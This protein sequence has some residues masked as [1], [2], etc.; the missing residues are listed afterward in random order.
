MKRFCILLF[1]LLI[2]RASVAQNLS[3]YENEAAAQR[4]PLEAGQRQTS[5][6]AL[7][8]TLYELISQRHAVQQSHWNVQG[9]LFY[10]LHDLLGHFY[11]SLGPHIDAIAERKLAIGSAADGRPASV[12]QSADLTEVPEGHLDDQQVLDLLT[13]R[14]KT[15][16]DR[17]SER[18]EQTGQN[19]LVTQ[20]LLIGLN[21]TVDD[22]LWKLR[23][24]LR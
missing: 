23:A 7:Q 19:D 15:I 4:I 13:E 5:A 6:D 16:S 14:Y 10:S 21:H 3:G 9:P 1:A 11:E 20:D 12:V 18:I 2:S 8:A 17:L 24:F 22:H